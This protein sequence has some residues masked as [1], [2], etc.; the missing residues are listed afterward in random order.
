MAVLVFLSI[1]IFY[2]LHKSAAACGDP[3][4]DPYFLNH[5]FFISAYQQILFFCTHIFFVKRMP[6]LGV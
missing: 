1:L 2:L 4:F 5:V 3:T 6:R